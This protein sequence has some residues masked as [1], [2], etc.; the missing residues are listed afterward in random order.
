VS[1][2]TI[3]DRESWNLEALYPS[4]AAFDAARDAFRDLVLPT[5]ERHR[6]RLGSSAAALAD[7]LDA[8][9][10]AGRELRRLSCYASTRADED[11]RDPPRQGARRA[12][13]LLATELSRRAS[14]VRPEILA[15]SEETVLRF[16]ADEPRLA[17]HAHSLRDLLRQREH[18]LGAAEERILAEANLTRH[19]ASSLYQILSNAEM[20]RPTVTLSTGEQVT[21]TPVSFQKHRS[22]PVREDRLLLFPANFGAYAAFRETLGQNLFSAV[23]GHVFQARS[24]S[25]RSS[26]QAALDPDNVPEGVYRNLVVQVRRHL[27]VLHRYFRLRGRVLGVDPL[28]Y[29]DLYCPLGQ[30]PP[31]PWDATDARA[32]VRDG[33]T[34]LGAG[35]VQALE[36]AF[37][38][39]WVDWHPAPGKRSGAYANGWAYD[40]HPF[41]LLNFNGDYESVLTLAHEMGHAMHSHF[42][43]RTQPYPTADYSIFV[44]EVA[45]TFNEILVLRHMLERADSADEERHL[46]AS[47]LD[48]I[49]GTL[50]RQ[51]MFAE[52]EL[53]IH[54][55]V[56]GGEVLTGESLTE[57]YL[58]LLRTYHGEGEGV[59]AIRPEYAS[60]WGAIPHMYYD[61][62]VYQYATGIVA[63]TALARGVLDGA[64]GARERYLEFLASG[65][66]DYP[67]E[68][69]RRAGVDLESAEPYELAFRTIED[70]VERLER[71]LGRA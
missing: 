62:Y 21:L 61:F 17:P 19:D 9:A 63:A 58:D 29:A 31:R 4:P 38:S 20:P 5:V 14:Y 71:S 55:R 49:R 36:H 50:F 54:E 27:P 30:A 44:A 67:L 69:L 60:E 46:L 16:V 57:T 15:M 28:D 32:A 59:M 43:N 8:L 23:K 25:Y 10:A 2:T 18:V 48:G 33:L 40:V 24:R 13:E 66:S 34:P 37:A 42:S 1:T 51:A 11:L 70:H 39:R 41:V 52:F 53:A 68:L 35:Y 7:A 56:E 6:G 12:V 47:Y 26:L 22:T 45:S 65:G 64:A 3:P